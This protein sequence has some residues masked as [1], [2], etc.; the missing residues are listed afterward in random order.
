MLN[1]AW[2]AVVIES[3]HMGYC[4]V[5]PSTVIVSF[6]LSRAVKL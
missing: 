4:K 3:N 2:I 6:L 5:Q 1:I